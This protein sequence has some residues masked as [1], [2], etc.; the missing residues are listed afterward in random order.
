MANA[1]PITLDGNLDDWNARDR[2]DRGLDAGYAIHAKSDGDSFAF[3]LTAPGGV[4]A[5]TTVWLNTDRN[6][7]TG[8]QVFGFAGGAE[9]NVNFNADGTVSLYTGAAG[10]TLV[11]ANLQAAWSADR[12]TVEF[13]VPKAAIGNPQAIDTLYDVNDQVFLP[14][15]YSSNPF[16]VFNDVGAATDPAARI[17]IVWSET[18]A[19]AFFSKTA[20]SQLFMAAQ[21]QAMQAGVPFDILT[22]DDLTSVATLAKYDSI[23]FPS[24][25]NVAAGKVDAIAHALEQATKQYGIGLIAAGEFMTNDAAG[26]ALPGDSY[27]RMKLLFDATRVTGG[28]PADVTIRATDA[29]GTV[30][31]GYTQGQV[32]HEYKGVGWNAFTSVSGTGQTIATATV[33]D[34]THAAAIATHTGGRNVIFSSEAVMADENLLQKA[35]D[36]SV[37]GG[38]LSVGLQMTR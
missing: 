22:E 13:R 25:R 32:V 36:Y 23:V 5:N 38:G 17:A 4:G 26:N 1:A 24:F 37:H 19:N 12:T 18:T 34:Q 2:I 27:A 29:N 28:W 8:H 16:T 3:A 11:L 9:Y 10:E 21:A 20:Y 31:D 30:L 35:I 15:S 14:G 33:Y 6:A 7:A